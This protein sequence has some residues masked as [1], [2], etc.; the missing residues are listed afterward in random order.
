MVLETM[1]SRTER[2]NQADER[3]AESGW[4][5]SILDSQNSQSQI[6]N[7]AQDSEMDMEAVKAVAKQEMELKIAQLWES[8][9]V[10]DK[11]QKSFLAQVED[12]RNKIAADEIGDARL[13]GERIK[14]LREYE[15]YLAEAVKKNTQDRAELKKLEAQ[16]RTVFGAPLVH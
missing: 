4:P 16:Y 15:G 3:R 10:S 12:I 13:N 11:E 8:V 6:E 1:G 7:G 5:Q 2:S 14:V 9:D